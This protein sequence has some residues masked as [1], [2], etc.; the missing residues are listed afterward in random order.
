MLYA[1]NIFPM[2]A[3]TSLFNWKNY[4]F[5]AYTPITPSSR[6]PLLTCWFSPRSMQ[7]DNSS[8][9]QTL[10]VQ[11]TPRVKPFCW[12][13]ENHLSRRA[14][15]VRFSSEW[16]DFAG[17][18]ENSRIRPLSIVHY[19]S[20]MYRFVPF[21]ENFHALQ[22]SILQETS[23]ESILRH[24]LDNH[25]VFKTIIVHSPGNPGKTKT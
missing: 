10:A 15:I 11:Y 22:A 13:L 7:L 4:L 3:Y 20:C 16:R 2:L 18:L 8:A 6:Y 9:A 14:L 23:R 21:L 12:R 24:S 5:S 25:R 19:V 17:L 1:K